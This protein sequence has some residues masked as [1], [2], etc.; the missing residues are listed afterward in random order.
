[1]KKITKKATKKATKKV[2]KTEHGKMLYESL[3]AHGYKKLNVS[4]GNKKLI[5]NDETLFIIWN[6]PAVKTCPNLTRHCFEECYARKAETVYKDCLPSRMKNWEETKQADFIPNMLYTILS[7]I[8]YDRKHRNIVVRI[9]ESGDFYNLTYAMAWLEIAY[10][11]TGENVEFIFY[12][13]SFRF[14]D[15]IAIPSNMAMRASVWDD[16]KESDLEIIKRN[17]WN[18]YTAVEQFTETDTFTQCRCEDC[19][20]CGHC[21]DNT[22]KMIACEIH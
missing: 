18:I 20:T 21:W 6:L 2:F 13:K 10:M 19:A 7:A 5:S 4:R 12:T 3:K 22:R 9:H 17:G 11:L 15:G 8:R 1:M 14:F 16:T